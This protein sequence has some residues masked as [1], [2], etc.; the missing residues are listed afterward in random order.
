MQNQSSTVPAERA[1]TS[2][3]K[4]RCIVCNKEFES[5]WK[6][7]QLTCGSEECQ[8]RRENQTDRVRRDSLKPPIVT[9]ECAHCGKEFIPLVRN[10]RTKHCSRKCA[11][12]YWRLRKR[13]AR[14]C[15]LCNALFVPVGHPIRRKYCCEEHMRIGVK[16][17]QAEKRRL[18]SAPK[19]AP[20]ACAYSPCGK[21]FKPHG[22]PWN[23]YCSAL[24]RQRAGHQRAELPT[25]KRLAHKFGFTL[26]SSVELAEAERIL[27][28]QA[29]QQSTSTGGAPAKRGAAFLENAI[30]VHE[31]LKS[32]GKTAL[33]LTPEEAAED[34]KGAADSL[35]LDCDYYTKK[36]RKPPSPAR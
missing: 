28:Q 32:W 36:R 34:L 23:K 5:R 14:R 30:A 3:F 12:T 21:L 33:K 9:K 6:S 35:R 18:A 20:R 26:K 1:S 7:R 19:W 2:K 17:E 4:L 27:A 11:Y 24:C 29:Q 10:R 8:R 16:Q 15:A 13:P 22:Q 25:A 31:K